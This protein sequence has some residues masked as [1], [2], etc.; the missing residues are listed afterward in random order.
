MYYVPLESGFPTLAHGKAMEEESH[1][2]SLAKHKV[3]DWKSEEACEIA[4]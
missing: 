4:I 2:S 1:S 3:M